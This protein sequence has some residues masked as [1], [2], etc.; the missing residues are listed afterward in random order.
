MVASI[1]KRLLSTVMISRELQSLLA[2][3]LSLPKWASFRC[4]LAFI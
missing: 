4:L 2:E 1:D 3:E